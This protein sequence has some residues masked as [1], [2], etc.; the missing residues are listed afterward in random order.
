[1]YLIQGVTE[2]TNQKQNLV[3]PDGTS[4]SLT[5]KFIPM[6]YGWFIQEL[7]YGGFTLQGF[8]VVTSPNML[9]Q[10]LNQIPFGLA[11]YTK[12]NLE[13]TQQKDFSSGYATL[14]LL[15]DDELVLYE[16]LLSD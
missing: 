11:C 2:D 16:A 3:L 1:M 15:D 9:H 13:P 10:Y 6:Q 14:Y 12:D 5:L 7:V 4:L 8:R